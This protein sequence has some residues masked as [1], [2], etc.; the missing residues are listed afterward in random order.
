MN[1]RSS[2]TDSFDTDQS[3]GRVNGVRVVLV[4]P[5]RLV[6]EALAQAL[7]AAEGPPIHVVGQTAST[8]DA[9]HLLDRRVDV[10]VTAWDLTGSAAELIG[11]A[12]ARHP[13][14]EVLVVSGHEDLATVVR[15][16]RAGARGYVAKSAGVGELADA[17]R[18]VATGAVHLSP[19]H[20]GAVL[21]NLVQNPVGGLDALSSR[22]FELLRMFGAGL[23][24]SE[25]AQRLHVSV[26]TASTYRARLLTKLGLRTTPELVRYSVEHGVASR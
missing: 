9:I 2:T 5:L 1:E 8:T 14:L 7:R 12:H 17:I 15:A 25:A 6:R 26:S 10:L 4:E 11:A 19:R 23:T 21:E 16:M 22:E 18:R 13:E 24:L 20:S 3:V